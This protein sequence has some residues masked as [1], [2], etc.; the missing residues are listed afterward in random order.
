MFLFFKGKEEE[1][2]LDLILEGIALK[3]ELSVPLYLAAG[4][5]DLGSKYHVLFSFIIFF[6]R[7]LYS[8]TCHLVRAEGEGLVY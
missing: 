7:F 6:P 5:C 8:V 4:H 2:G 1:K 3:K